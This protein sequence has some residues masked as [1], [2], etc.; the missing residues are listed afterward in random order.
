MN[1]TNVEIG[2]L[3]WQDYPKFCDAYVEDC[4]IDGVTATEEQLNAINDDGQLV[5][6]M[7]WEYVN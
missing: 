4:E 2:G 6:E 3:D 1:I 7:V 5:Y